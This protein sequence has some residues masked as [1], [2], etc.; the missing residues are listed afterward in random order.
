MSWRRRRRRWTGSDWAAYHTSNRNY[1]SSLVG[2]IDED[3]R[4]AF[5]NL[6]PVDLES[7]FTRY[8]D[9]FG[10]GAERYSRRTYEEWRAGRTQMSGETLGRLLDLVPDYLSTATKVHLVSR[11]R[12]RYLPPLQVSLV[13]SVQ[14]WREDTQQAIKAILDHTRSQSLPE[15]VT[16]RLTWLSRGDAVAARELVA[17]AEEQESRQRLTYL[18][19]EFRRIEALLARLPRAPE[20][21]HTI[22]LPRGRIEL[23]LRGRAGRQATLGERGGL[24][25]SDRHALVR[26]EDLDAAL[27]AQQ[28]QGNLLDLTLE[29]LDTKQQALILAEAAKAK[30]RLDVSRKEADQRFFDS[31][32]DMATTVR[33]V[34][35]LEKSTGSD[36]EIRSTFETASGTTD[37]KV[38]KSNNLL[39]VVIA[40]V[41]GVVVIALLK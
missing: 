38:K 6:S 10:H 20:L 13:T 33:A 18:E 19:A 40:I 5:F 31:T 27:S 26:R 11:I 22:E 14:D 17:T 25:S 39:I 32:R 24:V 15:P 8:G 12:D 34:E 21:T 41:L 37:L 3:I 23:T 36:Y 29:K 1:L 7:L 4:R 30:L 16:S 9:Q 35:A 28:R 2:G